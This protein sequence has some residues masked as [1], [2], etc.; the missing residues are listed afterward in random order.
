MAA[1]YREKSGFAPR[2]ASDLGLR[3]S[4][5]AAQLEKLSQAVERAGRDAFPQTAAGMAL[6][7]LAQVRGFGRRPALPAGGELRF[8]RAT[9]A[10]VDIPIPAGT[11]C[12]GPGGLRFATTMSETLAQGE[13]EVSV[14][15]VAVES[16]TSGNMAAFA[17]GAIISPLPGVSAVS[18]PMAF[19]GGTEQEDDEGLRARLLEHMADPP[20]AF[21]LAFYRHGALSYPGVR[22]VQ[23]LPM[24]RGVG[25]VDVYIAA[26]PGFDP[27][28]LA[29]NLGSIFAQAR[30]IGTSVQ[31]RAAQQQPVNLACVVR[32]QREHEHAWVLEDCRAAISRIMAARQVGEGLTIARLQSALIV[33]AG[34]ENIRLVAPAADIPAQEGQ[35]LVAG[36]LEVAQ[37]V[38]GMS[39][40]SAR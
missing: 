20:C 36:E 19:V 15:A 29:E 4:V 40:V 22:S 32:V 3:L 10:A 34:V 31:V 18:N 9:P 7:M 28:V 2:D 27:E 30:E 5:L 14:S 17:V 11:L 39:E 26:L 33:V 16:G 13:S 37:G 8:T 21:N 24:A 25:S 38:L 35:L 1:A 12:A 23:V 6:D